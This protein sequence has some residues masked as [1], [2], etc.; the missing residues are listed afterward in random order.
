MNF[1]HGDM[2]MKIA[3][4]VAEDKAKEIFLYDLK[5]Y[6]FY[7]E[8]KFKKKVV[9]CLHPSSNKLKYQKIFKE[10]KADLKQKLIY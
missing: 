1:D 8:K 7:L 3:K 10:F 9:L 5:N 6:F 4:E 2:E